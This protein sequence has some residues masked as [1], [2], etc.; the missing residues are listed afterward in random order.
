MRVTIWGAILSWLRIMKTAITM[1]SAG[2][3]EATILPIG[4]SPSSLATIPPTAP[5][6]AAAMTKMIAAATTFGR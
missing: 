5:A 6:R 4:V 3:T 1:I 2:T